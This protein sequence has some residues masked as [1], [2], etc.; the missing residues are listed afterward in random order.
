MI[1]VVGIGPGYEDYILPQAIKAIQ[2]ADMVIGAKR[3][4][5]SVAKYC[6]NT[7][8][9]S[10]GFSRITDYIIKE[11][12]SEI[13]VVVSGDSGFYSMLD[14]VKRT[15]GEDYMT[16]IP[17]ISSLQ[18]F[19]SKL[20]KGYEQSRWISLHGRETDL[21]PLLEQ[22]VELGILTDQK[23][24]VNYIAS[25]LKEKGMMK[26]TIFVGERLSYEDEKISRLTVEEALVYKASPLSV[27][28]ISYE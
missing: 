24:N 5:Q 12:E 18:Y 11:K 25:I 6:Q 28:V 4:L 27:V 14:F 26:P 20:K 17:G 22:Q 13:T 16:V 8:D 23:Q 7:M 21:D 1:R 2:S 15:V 10:I 9:L 3:N 19:Y